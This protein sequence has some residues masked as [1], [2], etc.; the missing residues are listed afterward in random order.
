MTRLLVTC[1]CS[2]LKNFSLSCNVGKDTNL[3]NEWLCGFIKPKIEELSL[4]FKEIREPLVFP[5][6][7]FTCATLTEFFLD[8]RHVFKLPSYIHF[9]CLQTLTLFNIIFPDTSSTQQLF[10]GCPALEDLSLLDC[11]WKNV[12]AV[13]IYSP[14]LRRIYIREDED[15]ILGEDDDYDNVTNCCEVLIIGNNLKSFTY[16]G[17]CMNKYFLH[18]S[19]LVIDA[20]IQVLSRTTSL[21][22]QLPLFCNLAELSFDFISSIE[23]SYAA[24]LAILRNSPCLQVLNFQG[25]LSLAKDNANCIFDPLPV[26]FSTTLRTI[27][28][29][30]ITWKKDELFAIKILLKAATV[31]DNLR[32]W[33]CCIQ[34]KKLYK[35]ILK[36]R[37][38][39]NSFQIQVPLSTPLEHIFKEGESL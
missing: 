4:Q 27:E 26:C 3:V 12:Q 1:N 32:I 9:Q 29:N 28:I 18:G 37:N 38:S 13:C 31:L 11:N 30:C 2:N 14:L 15:D 20:S 33:G 22:G 23:L 6:Q 19:T 7:L 39:S 8:M 16:N 36:Y 35:Q 34:S 25:G 21:L 10:C 5:A 17:N 24:L